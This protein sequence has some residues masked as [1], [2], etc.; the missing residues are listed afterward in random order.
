MAMFGIK[1]V[2]DPLAQELR[3]FGVKLI[4]TL[5]NIFEQQ[6]TTNRLLAT[7]VEQPAKLPVSKSPSR[8]RTVGS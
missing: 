1:E 5:D 3:T 6:R 8:G 7:L 2:L 4:D